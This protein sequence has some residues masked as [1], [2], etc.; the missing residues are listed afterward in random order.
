[1]SAADS[2]DSATAWRVPRDIRQH[3][4]V[5]GSQLP[6][7]C[8]H[9]GS[10]PCPLMKNSELVAKLAPML[11]MA[12]AAAVGKLHTTFVRSAAEVQS[13][14]SYEAVGANVISNST[15]V[16]LTIE[17]V[18]SGEEAAHIIELARPRMQRG[19]VF[20]H[21]QEWLPGISL[22]PAGP[23]K[24][25]IAGRTNTLAWLQ[26]D[27]T[28]VVRKVV[29]RISKMVGIPSAHAEKMQV[30]RYENGQ[31]CESREP[32]FTAAAAALYTAQRGREISRYFM[33]WVFWVFCRQDARR[34]VRRCV[35]L[36]GRAALG[37]RPGI[38]HNRAGGGRRCDEGGRSRD[39]ARDGKAA[40]VSQLHRQDERAGSQRR[41]RRNAGAG[42]SGEVGAQL[43]VP[44]VSSS[45]RSA[46]QS[47]PPDRQCQ[48]GVRSRQGCAL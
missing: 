26:H 34:W 18:L 15:P 38:S 16:A 7:G 5:G 9:S 40:G 31:E 41:P 44:R 11:A 47:L 13:L 24:A 33:R 20:E 35:E 4:V 12:V 48:A 14:P 25:R 1:V 45:L 17:R 10:G 42:R 36:S 37:N 23:R 2:H 30:I 39:P 3:A 6:V 28:P 29:E 32:R 43:M 46:L 22:P 21:H 19:Q 8:A 27:E